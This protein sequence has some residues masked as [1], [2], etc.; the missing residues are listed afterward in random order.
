MLNLSIEP[1]YL[2]ALFS[3]GMLQLFAVISPGPDFA[4]VTRN[5]VLYS[6][7][8]GLFTVLGISSWIFFHMIYMVLGFGLVVSSMAKMLSL[9]KVAGS[10]YLCYL[11]L[12]GLKSSSSLGSLSDTEA[13]RVQITPA[14]AFL[15]GFLT[16][17]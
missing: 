2:N 9:I 5:S 17:L 15:N 4:L 6:R 11:G 10:L 3:I 1:I 7:K 12:K 13:K 16:N 14:S 8:A